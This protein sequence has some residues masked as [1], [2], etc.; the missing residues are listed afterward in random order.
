MMLGSSYLIAD[1]AGSGLA[2]ASGDLD[3][4][5]KFG[6]IPAILTSKRILG[7]PGAVAIS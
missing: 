2:V 4:E 5:H 1:V 3:I 6:D 7:F